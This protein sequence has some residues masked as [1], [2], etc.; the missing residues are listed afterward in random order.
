M[1][2]KKENK[3]KK[4]KL[5]LTAIASFVVL[6]VVWA[7]LATPE[8]AL[9]KKPQNPGGGTDPDWNYVVSISGSSWD[10]AT[11]NQVWGSDIAARTGAGQVSA[12]GSQLHPTT[13]LGIGADVIYSDG[14]ATGTGPFIA[15]Y[16]VE[17]LTI[18]VQTDE[19]TGAVTG[20]GYLFISSGT[21]NKLQLRGNSGVVET[22]V[23]PGEHHVNVTL[24]PDGPI[25]VRLDRWEKGKR[26]E[27]PVVG[28][29]VMGAI[30]YTLLQAP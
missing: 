24:T 4:V 25:D 1:E 2:T 8:T 19:V 5:Y 10:G 16:Q 26:V 18:F 13:S 28:Q 20:L 9:A 6:V 14:E 15:G 27:G 30:D 22:D 12:R 23:I 11:P 21:G 3:G 7:A 17:G 29:V